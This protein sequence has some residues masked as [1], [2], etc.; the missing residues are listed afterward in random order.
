MTA[1]EL[2]NPDRNT[3][4]SSRYST[5]IDSIVI[6]HKA[7]YCQ[8]HATSVCR[9]VFASYGKS[10]MQTPFTISANYA[11]DEEL[12]LLNGHPAKR[13][14][15]RRKPVYFKYI[16]HDNSVSKVTFI[17]TPIDGDPDI[18]VSRLAAQPD[19]DSSEKYS[20][21][22]LD[23]SVT[24]IRGVDAAYLEGTYHISIRVKR[25]YAYFTLV[26]IEETED[27]HSRIQLL[28]GIS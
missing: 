10:Q 22:Y 3:I 18:Y 5:R 17:V 8:E 1:D 9:Y 24:F 19:K 21:R 12:V 20:D 26:A 27:E 2:E 16:V 6:E 4:W 7:S 23:D 15:Y 28:P 14:V 13:L 25:A 11:E